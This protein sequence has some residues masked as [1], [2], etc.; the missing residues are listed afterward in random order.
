MK[1]TA[2]KGER[3]EIN[4]DLVFKLSLEPIN[5]KKEKTLSI[6]YTDIELGV[7]TVHY[8]CVSYNISK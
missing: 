2:R 4:K 3:K 7:S 6:R 5:G 1:S 8:W